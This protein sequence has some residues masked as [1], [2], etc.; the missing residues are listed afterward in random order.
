MNTV[1]KP[2]GRVAPGWMPV[3]A[4]AALLLLSASG[5]ALAWRCWYSG[6]GW[7]QGPCV[8]V[9]NGNFRDDI[10]SREMNLWCHNGPTSRSTKIILQPFDYF[11]C[12]GS[13]DSTNV[14]VQRT[15]AGCNYCDFTLNCAGHEY[16]ILEYRDGDE[17]FERSSCDE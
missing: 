17:T 8:T 15:Q 14:T 13:G 4:V 16:L 10:G 12:R 6:G 5:T 3:G 11:V 1:L 9:V 7:D 2:K